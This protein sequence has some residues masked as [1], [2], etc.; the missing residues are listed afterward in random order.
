MLRQ[1]SLLF[2]VISL[3]T[4]PL[5]GQVGQTCNVNQN[6]QDNYTALLDHFN[7]ST[8]G[9]VYGSVS[10][11]AGVNGLGSAL[12]F[13]S[14]SWVEYPLSG[15][16][17]W[18]SDYSPNGKFGAIELWIKRANSNVGNFLVINWNKTH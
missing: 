10:Y 4:I 8:L 6:T 13:S 9:Q 11:G 3:T 14:G 7:G 5:L 16:Y 15:W 2:L 18:S 17:Q 1:S 12:Q